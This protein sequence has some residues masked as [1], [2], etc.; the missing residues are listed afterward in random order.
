MSNPH[1]APDN[2]AG[3]TAVLALD[4]RLTE[5]ERAREYRRNIT[6]MA[7]KKLPTSHKKSLQNAAKTVA[8]GDRDL[9]AVYSQSVL[10][11][12]HV[13]QRAN[14]NTDPSKLLP[15]DQYRFWS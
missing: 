2:T 11:I 5:S 12:D 9:E 4:D 6:T 13:N 1:H 15:A 10:I 3:D 8:A 14:I 7:W